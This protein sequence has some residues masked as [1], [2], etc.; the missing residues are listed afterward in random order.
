M[1]NIKIGT[2]G[3]DY[4]DWIGPF[5]PKNLERS[6]HLSYYSKIFDLVEINSTFYNIPTEVMVHNWLNRVSEDFRFIVKV[7]QEITHKLTQPDSTSKIDEFFLKLTPLKEKI[8][9]F[10][11]QFPPWFNY[12]EGHLNKLTHLLELI[13]Y[14]YTY[15]IE[16]RNNSWFNDKILHEFIDGERKILVTTY[17]PG[18]ASFYYNTQKIYYIRLIGDRELSVFNQIQ[19]GQRESLDDLKNNVQILKNSPNIREIFI[20]VNN[21]FQGFAPES[22]S[23]L[24]K[25]WGLEYHQFD[26]QK[27]LTDFL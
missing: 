15:F 13:P 5:Y 16:L 14:D 18:V 3:W 27:R 4:K 23:M 7:W 12:S 17:I 11:L 22:A 1:V 21:H 10:L 2:A 25:D 8:V 19:R 20:I 24:K 6:L 9:G 26:T